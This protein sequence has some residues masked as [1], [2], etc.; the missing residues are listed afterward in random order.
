[1]DVKPEVIHTSFGR[2]D[3][4]DTDPRFPLGA[5]GQR[6]LKFTVQDDDLLKKVKELAI[7]GVV[8][9]GSRINCAWDCGSVIANLLGDPNCLD[10]ALSVRLTCEIPTPGLAR[11][12]ALELK[13]KLRGYQ[14]EA[15]RYLFRRA[16]ALL[17]DDPRT[18]KCLDILGVIVLADSQKVLILCNNLGKYVWAAEVAKWLDEEA[19]LLF[20]RAGH[21]ARVFCKA[22]MGSGRMPDESSQ[23]DE[24][25]VLPVKNC[26]TCLKRGRARGERLHLARFLEPVEASRV[27]YEPSGRLKKD[28]TPRMSRRAV[29]YCPLPAV[30]T[31]PT[32]PDEVDSY[33]RVCSQC[34]AQVHAAVSRAR[35]IIVNYDIIMGQKDKTD[36]GVEVVRHDLPGWG[37]TLASH[38]FDLAVVSESHRLR[39]WKTKSDKAA[40]TRVDRAYEVCSD[41]ERVY[42][43]TGTPIHGFTRDLASQLSLISGGLWS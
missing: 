20:G 29:R 3:I 9:R 13:D 40:Q 28:G 4:A 16:Y 34:L 18:G 14:R 30:F 43:E 41:I 15:V 2:I 11:Y 38:R 12:K 17:G 22:C 21:E 8:I 37:P 7:P 26:P 19:V 35:F 42:A 33:A 27:Y 32:H 25:G 10:G 1:M 31:C 39:G 24:W 6:P 5:R 36:T 23:P